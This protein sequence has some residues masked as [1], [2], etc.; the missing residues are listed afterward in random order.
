MAPNYFGFEFIDAKI[1]KS[2]GGGTPT[3]VETDLLYANQIEVNAEET[4]YVFEGDG[5]RRELFGLRG[6][7]ILFRP[8]ALTIAAAEAVF[9][10][11]AVTSSLPTGLARLT[12]FGDEAEG[13]GV[14]AGFYGRAYAVKNDGGVES[15]VTIRLWIPLGTLTLGPAPTLQTGQKVGQQTYRLA[16]VRTSKDVIGGALPG[17][18]TGGA[19]YAIAEES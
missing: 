18:P 6:M 1:Q 9:A 2:S 5:Q 15:T 19:F 7:S 14:A 16:A 13:K 8:D 10:K 11:T 3:I 12:W 17:V 4:S